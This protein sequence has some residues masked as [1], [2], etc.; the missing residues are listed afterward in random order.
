MGPF[1]IPQGLRA[2]RTW[3]CCSEAVTSRSCGAFPY[4]VSPESW[5]NGFK[6][7]PQTHSCFLFRTLDPYSFRIRGAPA[8]SVRKPSSGLCPVQLSEGLGHGPGLC[9]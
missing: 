1:P 9:T 4:L 8:R 5:G 3:P 7:Q 6:H 2:L